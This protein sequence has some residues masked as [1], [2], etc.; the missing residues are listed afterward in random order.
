MRKRK[1][2]DVK[3]QNIELVGA[4]AHAV[5]HQHVIGDRVVDI[6]VEAQRHA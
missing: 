3:V 1:K 4:L 6:L 5:E 2:V